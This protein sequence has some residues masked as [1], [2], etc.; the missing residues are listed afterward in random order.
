MLKSLSLSHKPVSS[1]GPRQGLP[2]PP[3]GLFVGLREYGY[4]LPRKVS[5]AYFG[6]SEYFLRKVIWGN[7]EPLKTLPIRHRKSLLA[8]EFHRGGV[9]CWLS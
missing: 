1:P 8:T 2:F 9:G 7:F 3:V 6:F 4:S 5:R